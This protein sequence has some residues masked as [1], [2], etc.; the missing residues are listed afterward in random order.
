M[1]KTI[2]ARDVN[3]ILVFHYELVLHKGKMF[4]RDYP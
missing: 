3:G 1:A 4:R 2:P